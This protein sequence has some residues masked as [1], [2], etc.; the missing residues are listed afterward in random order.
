MYYSEASPARY[1]R[2]SLHVI[3]CQKRVFSNI[4][5]LYNFPCISLCSF[6]T[7]FLLTDCGSIVGTV[8][9]ICRLLQCWFMYSRMHRIRIRDCSEL[10]CLQKR[11]QCSSKPFDHKLLLFTVVQMFNSIRSDVKS[12]TFPLILERFE[13]TS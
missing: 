12:H 3:L 13:E 4:F 2:S 7:F 1:S 10:E 9:R 11:F 6:S 8:F 5:P